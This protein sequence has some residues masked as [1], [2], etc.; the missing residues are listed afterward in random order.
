MQPSGSHSCPHAC[1]GARRTCAQYSHN[2]CALSLSQSL[3]TVTVTVPLS[4]SLRTVTVTWTLTLPLC[5]CSLNARRVSSRTVSTYVL[6]Y[7]CR[8]RQ[9]PCAARSTSLNCRSHA[10]LPTLNFSKTSSFANGLSSILWKTPCFPHLCAALHNCK[11][12]F[13]AQPSSRRRRTLSGP[14]ARCE[15]RAVLLAAADGGERP[16]GCKERLNLLELL[17]AGNVCLDSFDLSNR[18]EGA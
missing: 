11:L 12:K 9:V 6:T 8:E 10:H 17:Y 4:L 18:F 7:S 13:C 3:C 1:R 2:P 14:A 16:A 15:I 5:S